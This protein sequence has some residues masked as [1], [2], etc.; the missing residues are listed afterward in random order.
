[1]SSFHQRIM[2]YKKKQESVTNT[3]EKEQIN[4]LWGA[5][6]VGIGN[7]MKLEITN[8]RKTYGMKQK[9]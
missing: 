8:K 6:A 2:R 1:M 7:G 5:S 3:Q 4:L 9:Q